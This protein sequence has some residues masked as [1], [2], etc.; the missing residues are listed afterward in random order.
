M[1]TNRFYNRLKQNLPAKVF[2]IFT[3]KKSKLKLEKR[4]NMKLGIEIQKFN[5]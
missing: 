1:L 5:Y 3:R 4:S 2:I